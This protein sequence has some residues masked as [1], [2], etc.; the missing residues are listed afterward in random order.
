MSFTSHFYPLKLYLILRILVRW[1]K[2]EDELAPLLR[3]SGYPTRFVRGTIE[4]FA[5][6]GK[7]IERVKNLIGIDGSFRDVGSYG[8]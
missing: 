4:F 5:S 3:A 2:A 1:N 7:P 8:A 6:D